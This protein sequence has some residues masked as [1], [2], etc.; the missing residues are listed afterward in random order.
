M[1]LRSSVEVDCDRGQWASVVNIEE[2]REQE[3]QQED[4]SCSLPPQQSMPYHGWRGL[5]FLMGVQLKVVLTAP[6]V[7]RS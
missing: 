2:D 3:Y 6:R 7:T 4:S 1:V 5:H